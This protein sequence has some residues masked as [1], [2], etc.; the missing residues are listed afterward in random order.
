MQPDS[1]VRVATGEVVTLSREPL[2]AA[3]LHAY[4]PTLEPLWSTALRPDALGVI[5]R[6]DRFWVFDPTGI[7][8][9]DLDGAPTR[10]VDL[11]LPDGMRVGGAAPTVGGVVIAMEHDEEHPV[12]HPVLMRIDEGGAVQWISHLPMD[13]VALGRVESRAS[14][15]WAINKRQPVTTWHCSYFKGGTVV[16]SR[17][18]VLAVFRDMPRSGIGMGYVVSVDDGGARYTTKMGPI[19]QVA[20]LEGGEF[21]VG[22]QGYGAF[23]THRYGADGTLADLWRSQGHYVVRDQD[24]RVVELRNDGGAMHLTRLAPGRTVARGA[25][26]NGY[27]T[28]RPCTSADGLLLFFRHG[29]VYAARDL[30]IAERLPVFDR[31]GNVFA[32]EME[33]GPGCVYV[34]FTLHHPPRGPS[35]GLEFESYLVRVDV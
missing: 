19:D 21:L 9:Y 6:G 33:L 30:S 18:A 2:T 15:R 13:G 28:S 11:S 14:D 8:V 34:G 35:R 3:F 17:E 7:G 1:L 4:S 16:S 20:A 27:Y 24:I 31:N 22:Y 32:T 12:A 23:E 29:F 5:V 10:R 26:L 25:R